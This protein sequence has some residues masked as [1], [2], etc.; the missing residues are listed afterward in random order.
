M[1]GQH[2][3]AIHSAGGQAVMAGPHAH[4]IHSLG[5]QAL[6]SGPHAQRIHSKGGKVGGLTR[7]SRSLEAHAAS[8]A[9]R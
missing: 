4:G 1:A 6:M 9:E 5:G 8:V 3:Q 2:A 7:P